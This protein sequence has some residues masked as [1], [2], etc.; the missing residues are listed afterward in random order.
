LNDHANL[1]TIPGKIG[2]RSALA[3]SQTVITAGK[4]CLFGRDQKRFA[5]HCC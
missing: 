3:S 2:H 5:F 4:A 1:L